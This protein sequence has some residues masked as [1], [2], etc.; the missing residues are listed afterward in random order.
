MV[1]SAIFSFLALFL[2]FT[3]LP[4]WA[5]QANQSPPV[6]LTTEEDHQRTMEMLGID[7]LRPGVNGSDPNAPNYVNYEEKNANPYPH[8]PDPLLTNDRQ[9]VTSP[10][11]WW[12]ERRPEIV[13]FF[14]REI[15]GRVPEQ[16]PVVSWEITEATDTTIGNI[17]AKK[18]R[19]V[20]HVDNTTYPHITVN[21][22]ANL[23][24]PAQADEPV[25]VIT[26][27]GFIQLPPFLKQLRQNNDDNSP[28][29]HQLVMEKGWGYSII[30]PNSIQAD[31]GAGLTKGIIGLV[32]KGQPRDA[33]D[34]GALRAWAWGASRLLDYFETIDE[35]DA[36]RVGIQGHSRYGKA[37]VVAQAFDQR[38]AIGYISSSGAGGVKPHRRNF[39]E[40]VE[41]VAA[42]SEYHWMVGNY[43]KYAG[44][45]TWRDIPVDSHEL[46]ALC[47]PRPMFI[48]SGQEGDL[49][50][51]P[52]GM[53]MAGVKAGP[54]YELLE[55][56]GLGTD[57]FPPVGTALLG[58][59]I[60]FRQHPEGHTAG[61]NWPAFLE[62]AERHFKK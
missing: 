52:K 46:V 30:V 6:E 25:P 45:L 4:A 2:I 53:F 42:P 41:N 51:D 14:E 54:V 29:W 16:T 8:Y 5:Q 36:E 40:I 13:E 49:W 26:Q 32:N 17:Q 44:P 11:M 35:V 7:S 62:F 37:A 20:G 9:K 39:G 61:P 31:N 12:N 22:Q 56:E 55:K 48:G 1:R 28:T 19:L 15:F 47:A 57:Q 18:K 33:D 59:D 24:I 50:V 21:I 38:F 58:G 23:V 60:A 3:V 27:F 10:E 43:L 34:W